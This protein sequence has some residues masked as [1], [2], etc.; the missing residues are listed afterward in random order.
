MPIPSETY[1]AGVADVQG[2]QASSAAFSG[3][4]RA[5]LPLWD[6]APVILMHCHRK[7]AV[8]VSP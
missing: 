6:E 7:P 5:G 8:I 3:V 1:A 2:D 4:Q